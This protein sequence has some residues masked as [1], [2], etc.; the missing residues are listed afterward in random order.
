[1]KKRILA[2]LLV[3]A[4]FCSIGSAFAQESNATQPR[5]SDEEIMEA[6]AQDTIDAELLFE[7]STYGL[8]AEPYQARAAYYATA[9]VNLTKETAYTRV[10]FGPKA[11]HAGYTEISTTF[12]SSEGPTSARVY[13]YSRKSSSDT[14]Q[15]LDEQTITLGNSTRNV[16]FIEGDQVYVVVMWVSGESGYCQFGVDFQ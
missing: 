9:T 16:D 8:E 15:K 4:F 5:L 2:L 12:I 1:M 7:I 3:F 14:L 13:T 6:L 10:I 11:V